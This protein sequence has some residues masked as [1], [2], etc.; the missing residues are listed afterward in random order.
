[1]SNTRIAALLTCHNRRDKTTACL[2]SLRD[3]AGLAELGVSL[4]VFMVDDGCT[5]GTA[6]AALEIWPE[7]KIISGDG[8]LY[9]CG[10]MRIAW[11]SAATTNPDYYLLVN[12]DTILFPQAVHE[13]LAIC[14]T[15]ETTAIAVGAIC[16]PHSGD[17]TYGGLQSDKPFIKNADSPRLCRTMNANCA[18]V[19]RVVFRKIGML[20]HAYQHAMG[21]MDY[22][23]LASKSGVKV[24][25]TPAFVGACK[26]NDTCGTWRDNKLPRIARWQKLF[27]VKGL[28]P[29]DWLYY[30]L[31]NCGYE[32]FRYWLSPYIK[33]LLGK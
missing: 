12:D 18:M 4:H 7:V 25:E 6:E 15:P 5:D 23:L 10:G 19:P 31:R 14:P 29:K 1:M 27:S 2:E 8:N 16:D 32:W 33:V 13:L 11:A 30:C 22:G 20:F 9:W 26:R 21:D 24:F 3:Q 17:W 28:P